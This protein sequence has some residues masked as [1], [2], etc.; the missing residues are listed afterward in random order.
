[1]KLVN[2][3]MTV[4]LSLCLM[5]VIMFI[6]LLSSVSRFLEPQTYHEALKKA[7]A[8]TAIQESIQDNLIDV[9]LF[10][11]I[12]MNVIED[13][14][15]ADEV[16]QFVSSDVDAMLSWLK[17][18]G[19]KIEALDLSPYE[20]RFDE[21]IANFFRDNQYYLDDEAKTDVEVMKENV[22]QIIKGYL[23]LFDFEKLT[24]SEPLM[25]VT[26]LIGMIDFKL[27]IGGLVVVVL[28]L[29]GLIVA[30]APRTMRRRSSTSDKPKKSPRRKSRKKIE[31][32]LLWSGYGILAGGLI[33]FI[34]FFSGVQ[35]GF[36]HY[37]VIQVAYLKECIAILIDEW[38]TSLYLY[39]LLAAGVGILLI[40]P[41]WWRLYK[42]YMMN[43]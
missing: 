13:F 37:T 34:I 41:Y 15:S 31:D 14:I 35:S 17:G 11:N 22:I 19:Q 42:K 33:I 24:A 16:K 23:R 26:K 39:G 6:C 5:F 29:V 32:G 2:K 27:I 9:M 36:Y 8:Y 4:L 43:E 28:A 40:I 7:D 10:N 25:K 18:S 3:I 20:G 38:F 30:C 1:M 12:E 21:R